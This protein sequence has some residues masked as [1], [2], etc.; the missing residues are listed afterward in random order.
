MEVVPSHTV[1]SEVRGIKSPL[2]IECIRKACAITA[3]AIEH[4]VSAITE[5]ATEQNIYREVKKKMYELGAEKVPFLTVIAGWEGR[6]ICWDTLPTEY[7]IKTEDYL[8]YDK[9]SIETAKLLDGSLTSLKMSC[10]C[11]LTR[12]LTPL[13]KQ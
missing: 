7:R 4:G 12:I 6:S 2:E 8:S 5:G 11:I 9:I 3:Q 10:Y 1:V 13:C